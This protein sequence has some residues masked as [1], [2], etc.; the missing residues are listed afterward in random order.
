VAK[1]RE[2]LGRRIW[3]NY[4][5][6]IAVRYGEAARQIGQ[7]WSIGSRGRVAKDQSTTKTPFR[8]FAGREIQR[9]EVQIRDMQNSRKILESRLS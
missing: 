4:E 9:K 8:S 1:S 5:G 2:D 6:P 3:G 7:S